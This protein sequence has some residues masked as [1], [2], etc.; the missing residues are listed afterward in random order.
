MQELHFNTGVIRPVE[1]Y[2][3]AW[4]LIRDQYWM[5]F[6]VVF[7]A[8]LI[9]SIVGII[10]GALMCGIYL[11]LFDKYEGRPVSFDRLFK[12][13]E[14]FVPS[15]VLFL[16]ILIPVIIML[17]LVYLPLI[18]MAFAAQAMDREVAIALFAVALVVELIFAV[19]MVCVHTLLLFAFP[20][21]VDKRLGAIAAI[22]WSA[23]SVWG[24]MKGVVGL[25]FVGF[26]VSLAG[27]LVFCIGVYLAMPLI[28]AANVVAYRKVFPGTLYG[29][30]EPPPPNL[31]QGL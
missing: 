27:M 31:Y 11:C 17:I 16:L 2:K 6:G 29:P 28:I 18:G 25:F 15:F 9:S 14:F 1:C 21:I 10:A 22:K 13:F 8:M 12:G 24:N 26:V 4:D 20:L 23:R 5:I 3:E 19:I 30:S 7:V